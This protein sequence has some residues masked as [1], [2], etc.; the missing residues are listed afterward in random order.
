M[1]RAGELEVARGIEARGECTGEREAVDAGDFGRADD[2]AA[3]LAVGAEHDGAR[4]VFQRHLGTAGFERGVRV[5]GIDDPGAAAVGRLIEHDVEGAAQGGRAEVQ[6]AIERDVEHRPAVGQ[7]HRLG[8]A[9]RDRRALVVGCAVPVDHRTTGAQGITADAELAVDGEAGARDVGLG[10]RLQARAADIGLAREPAA[11]AAAFGGD[12]HGDVGL[13]QARAHARV[14]QGR[15]YARA[16]ENKLIHRHRA[17]VG[18][19]HRLAGLGFDEHFAVDREH[20]ADV[21]VHHAAQARFVVD[22]LDAIGAARRGEVDGD[23]AAP[24]VV[25]DQKIVGFERDPGDA[26][27]RNVAFGCHGVFLGD[28]GAGGGIAQHDAAAAIGER[29]ADAAGGEA[30]RQAV[31]ADGQIGDRG[32]AEHLRGGDDL[33]AAAEIAQVR[34][35]DRAGVDGDFLAVQS[36]G[37]RHLARRRADTGLHRHVDGAP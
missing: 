3:L 12:D 1:D 9:Q 14:A 35:A 16:T 11:A 22:E 32:A 30:A 8:F 31:D 37:K 17:A 25:G 2:A 4:A 26:G 23:I 28:A 27:Q 19:Q 5:A 33:Q 18:E 6:C 10:Q 21:G 29:G 13:R 34:H 7:G 36:I 15:S 24:A 20:A